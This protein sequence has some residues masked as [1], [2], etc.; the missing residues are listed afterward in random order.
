MKRVIAMV[1]VVLWGC[2]STNTAKTQYTV[3]E[4]TEWGRP[5]LLLSANRIL[6]KNEATFTCFK[7]SSLAPNLVVEATAGAIT[8]SQ[9]TSDTWIYYAPDVG[10]EQ[11][12][13]CRYE[14]VDWP[15]GQSEAT[16]IIEKPEIGAIWALVMNFE[17]EL[18]IFWE[19]S[20]SYGIYDPEH[21]RFTYRTS[22]DLGVN[23][24]TWISRAIRTSDN[25]AVAYSDIVGERIIRRLDNGK[26]DKFDI[27][28]KVDCMRDSE[29][30]F[31]G[32]AGK[33]WDDIF[34]YGQRAIWIDAD[35]FTYDYVMRYCEVIAVRNGDYLYFSG[36]NIGGAKV[37]QSGKASDLYV[38]PDGS[39]FGFGTD[40]N[41]AVCLNGCPDVANLTSWNYPTT[42]I[43][44][45]F[46]RV[47]GTTS[48]NVWAVGNLGAII[49][50]DGRAWAAV[51]SG[52][53][54]NLHALWVNDEESTYVGGDNGTF[55]HCVVSTIGC[56]S[57]F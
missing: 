47:S 16:I 48:S 38:A 57:V 26:L 45:D 10:G 39:V 56:E 27:H 31:G 23:G 20:E 54:E 24:T 5:R 2:G 17:N 55:L 19:N 15:A 36:T 29:D 50:F 49:H 28:G 35:S 22:K 34:F 14:G 52:T 41:S 8:P 1:L 9:I 43:D 21:G 6:I 53:S 4:V 42:P 3:E 51:N 33:S 46:I 11:T 18:E 44:E 12:I 25:R 40:R 32:L 30:E 7:G 37:F 13:K